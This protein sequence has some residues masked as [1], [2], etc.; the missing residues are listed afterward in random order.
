[1]KDIEAI[2]QEL[3]K[4]KQQSA[5]FNHNDLKTTYFIIT[6]QLITKKRDPDHFTIE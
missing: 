5:T 2:K 3:T 4:N 6:N 1:M